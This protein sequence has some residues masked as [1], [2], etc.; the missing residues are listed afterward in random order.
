MDKIIVLNS[1]GF[2]SITLINF[3]HRVWRDREIH[4]LHF[5]YGARNTVSQEEC[6]DRV[7][8]KLK[9]VNVKISL[10][11]FSWTHGEFY[12]VGYDEKTQYIEYRNMVFLSYALSYAQAV[13]AKQIYLATMKSDYLDCSEEF[14]THM[15]SIANMAGIEIVSPF[16]DCEWKLSLVEYAKDFVHKGDYFSCDNPVGGKPCGKCVDCLALKEVEKYL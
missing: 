16:S 14:L 15:N 1:G 11:P 9:A 12:K 2:D 4:S 6:V 13:G 7:C 8:D 5:L 10:P 3:L